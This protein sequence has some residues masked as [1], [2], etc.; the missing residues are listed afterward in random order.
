MSRPGT[1]YDN[2][3][4][5]S[6]MKTLKQEQVSGRRWRNIEELRAALEEFFLETYNLSLC[7]VRGALH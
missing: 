5:E 1:P 2:A 6:F 4:A 7:Q 3:K